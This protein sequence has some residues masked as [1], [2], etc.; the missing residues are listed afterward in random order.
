MELLPLSLIL[1]LAFIAD[2]LIGDPVYRLHPVRIMGRAVQIITAG[3]RKTGLKGRL[4]GVILTLSMIVLF[5]GAYF[6][7]HY[8]SGL[9][10][11]SVSVLLDLFICYSFIALK[12]LSDHIKP[13]RSAL[14]AED[15]SSAR[16]AVSMIVGR[17]VNLLDETGVI[18]ASIETLSENFVDGFLSPVFWF[19]A[20]GIAGAF[21]GVSPLFIGICMLIIFKAASTLDSMVGYKTDEFKEIGWAGARLDDV[22]NFIPARISIIVL[23]AGA[24]LSGLSPAGGIRTVMRDRLKHESPNSAH[25]ESFTAGALN[26]RLGGPAQ[27]AAGVKDKPWLGE[28]F[29]DP[30]LSNLDQTVRL[31]RYSAWT[32]I[33]ICVILL[34]SFSAVL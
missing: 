26:V 31:I 29:S 32:A 24:F 12:D 28:E 11:T 34:W 2:T 33:V 13:V 15:L 10:H 6:L 19:T 27:Y 18:R 22:M 14:A 17:D 16:R 25:S 7:L 5:T 1:T 9:I 20:G 3:I 21:T 4:T 23:S 30:D 8:I